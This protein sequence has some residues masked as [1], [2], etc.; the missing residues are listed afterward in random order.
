[1]NEDFFSN[2]MKTK[3]LKAVKSQSNWNILFSFLF[4]YLACG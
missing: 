3:E 1:M 2:S 4:L